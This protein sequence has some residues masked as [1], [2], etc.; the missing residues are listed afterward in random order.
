MRDSLFDEIIPL[1]AKVKT[2]QQID[3][4]IIDLL[5][6]L[7]VG[8]MVANTKQRRPELD[9]IEALTITKEMLTKHVDGIIKMESNNAPHK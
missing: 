8:A 6:N 2:P 5:L 7:T 1:L 3:S 9:L 4:H